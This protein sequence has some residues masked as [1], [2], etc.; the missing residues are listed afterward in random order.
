M[1]IATSASAPQTN[2]ISKVLE[3][4]LK[5]VGYSSIKWDGKVESNWLILD[6]GSIIVHI[7]GADERK[8][9]SLE[10]IWGKAGITYHM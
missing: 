1:I 7:M 4:E 2:A 10:D 3:E 5:K 9:Y 8:K 6:L